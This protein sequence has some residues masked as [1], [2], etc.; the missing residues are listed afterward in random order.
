MQ[1]NRTSKNTVNNLKKKKAISFSNSKCCYNTSISYPYTRRNSKTKAQK[2]VTFSFLLHTTTRLVPHHFINPIK[3]WLEGKRG[4]A[5][6]LT[7]THTRTHVLA[8][9]HLQ[10]KQ[11]PKTESR[12]WSKRWGHL[13]LSFY[14]QVITDST[15]T[16]SLTAVCYCQRGVEARARPLKRVLP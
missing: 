4:R 15:Q 6:T 5:H 10:N 7:H 3:G 12:K 14:W 9:A 11:F 8:T 1:E 16:G 2:Q 13:S